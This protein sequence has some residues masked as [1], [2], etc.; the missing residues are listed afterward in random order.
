MTIFVSSSYPVLNAGDIIKQALQQVRVLGADEAL[1]AY[2]GA[3]GLDYLNDTMAELA[4][5]TLMVFGAT[6][7]NFNLTAGQAVYTYGTGG[8]FNVTRPD[9]INQVFVRI[10]NID[11]PV[12]RI[13][14]EAYLN[15]SSKSSES[16]FPEFYAFEPDYALANFYVYPAPN[17][18]AQIHIDCHKAI[19]TFASVNDVAALPPAY[20]ALLKLELASRLA[21][22][23]STQLD[24]VSEDRRI[25]LKKKIKR[26]NVQPMRVKTGIPDRS[27]Y[28]I[29]ADR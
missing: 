11:Y 22:A 13:S 18:A 24:A 5:D 28:N 25:E 29:L 3:L 9:R 27:R 23:Y 19:L 16:N 14:R 10:N 2:D 12:E 15:L 6:L 8:D 7:E 17:T 4:E 1:N 21:P 26:N 20:V